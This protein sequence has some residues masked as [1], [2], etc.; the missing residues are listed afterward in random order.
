MGC[1]LEAAFADMKQWR[2][3]ALVVVSDIFFDSRR[4]KLVALAV[5]SAAVLVRE[6]WQHNGMG[7]F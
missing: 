6:P 5:R 3:D 1:E 4:D 7:S 2:I